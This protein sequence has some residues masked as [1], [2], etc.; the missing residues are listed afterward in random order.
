MAESSSQET[1]YEAIEI[2][3]EK[4]GMY[5]IR[6]AGIDPETNKPWKPTWEPKAMA[7]DLLKA[8]WLEK[9]RK[10]KRRSSQR[11]SY[12]SESISYR[13]STSSHQVINDT[14]TRRN[15]INRRSSRLSTID[16]LPGTP[17][18]SIEPRTKRRKTENAR[19]K[20]TSPKTPPAR[21]SSSP[22]ASLVSSKFHPTDRSSVATKENSSP[23][24]SSQKRKQTVIP[25]TQSDEEVDQ[26]NSVKKAIPPR[27]SV[28]RKQTIIHE[29]HEYSNLA[30]AIDPSSPVH[31]DLHH[32]QSS[33]KSP[34]TKTDKLFLLPDS[35]ESEKSTA[36]LINKTQRSKVILA[37]ET[38]E[39]TSSPTRPTQQSK[40]ANPQSPLSTLDK[41]A[42]AVRQNHPSLKSAG[43]IYDMLIPPLDSSGTQ[44]L[45]TGPINETRRAKV[46]LAE[47]TDENLS[48]STRPSQQSSAPNLPTTLAATLEPPLDSLE[49]SKTKAAPTSKTQTSINLAPKTDSHL[50]NHREPPRELY[51][52]DSKTA[53]L[54]ASLNDT[55]DPEHL[56]RIVNYIKRRSID[57]L[58]KNFLTKYVQDPLSYLA[59]PTNEIDYLRKAHELGDH[60]AFELKRRKR[61]SINLWLKMDVPAYPKYF[62]RW[63][64]SETRK[65]LGP[66]LFR[67][68]E[69]AR[70]STD[71]QSDS[72]VSDYMLIKS[73]GSLNDAAVCP[74]SSLARPA[75]VEKTNHSTRDDPIHSNSSESQKRSTPPE[76]SDMD[77]T[78]QS[79]SFQ[80]PEN[81]HNDCSPAEDSVTLELDSGFIID[82]ELSQP[83][84]TSDESSENVPAQQHNES[85]PSPIQAPIPFPPNDFPR[86]EIPANTTL[87]LEISSSSEIGP[88]KSL[89]TDG[90]APPDGTEPK[91]SALPEGQASRDEIAPKKSAL[92]EGQA[93]RDENE[94]SVDPPDGSIPSSN[95]V[96]GSKESSLPSQ[97]A[98]EDGGDDETDIVDVQ[99]GRKKIKELKEALGALRKLFKGALEVMAIGHSKQAEFEKSKR[100]LIQSF[101][102]SQIDLTESFE[103][104]RNELIES[105]EKSKQELNE[106]FEKSTRELTEDLDKSKAELTASFEIELNKE[107]AIVADL[108]SRIREQDAQ[109]TGQRMHVMNYQLEVDGLKSKIKS[110]EALL[111]EEKQPARQLYQKMT[112]RQNQELAQIKTE[113]RLAQETTKRV[114]KQSA[115]AEKQNDQLV[116]SFAKQNENLR[117][118]LETV[119]AR[120]QTQA[121]QTKRL[122]LEIRDLQETDRIQ[123]WTIAELK[124]GLPDDL[125]STLE[126]AGDNS[127]HLDE[128]Q[129]TIE[130]ID[131]GSIQKETVVIESNTSA[132]FQPVS[133][134]ERCSLDKTTNLFDQSLQTIPSDNEESSQ[135]EGEAS[136]AMK[137]TGISEHSKTRATSHLETVSPHSSH[138][139]RRSC[140]PPNGQRTTKIIRSSLQYSSSPIC[141][142]R[143][144]TSLT[145]PTSAA[146]TTRTRQLHLGLSNE[147]PQ[148]SG[149]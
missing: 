126:E 79:E 111:I 128:D 54:I 65:Q 71:S 55:D 26:P 143:F 112:Q 100:E 8:D 50:S 81:I 122:Q 37:E 64:S 4:G 108:Q 127:T 93:P 5:H 82:P 68:P 57:P 32:N 99:G 12:R 90:Q 136:H 107:R 134:L 46:I 43:N 117:A 70:N 118:Q 132:T 45:K 23:L 133:Q 21:Q 9:K 41:N 61:G 123:K 98:S 10:R 147:S 86:D 22:P 144:G 13:S 60:M 40:T 140:P 120:Y 30:M 135:I 6:W 148:K 39:N 142:P 31:S 49:N 119:N 131:L 67:Y 24:N 53:E 149:S 58:D 94:P 102:K 56:S 69:F 38:D 3:K 73:S 34:T 103:K 63:D 88:K 36:S 124:S 137:L 66:M 92:P 44:S 16:N 109:S 74:S 105:F 141:P 101:E 78:L 48:S 33:P 14:T 11:N 2:L 106:G 29:T 47:E 96:A 35:F 104:S 130:S 80:P 116:D 85:A 95:S 83:L 77:C 51:E 17:S 62:F 91:K 1:E 125:G 42:A 87:P 114:Q 27:D 72:G 110:L 121:N 89:P 115:L 138:D 145:T 146:T 75:S 97:T 19:I 59:D 15:S 113:L 52:P 18:S 7:N 139:P 84:Q 25:E 129:P 20:T 76:D 28:K